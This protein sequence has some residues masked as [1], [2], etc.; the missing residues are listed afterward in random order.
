MAK[1][2]VVAKPFPYSEDGVSIRQLKEGE[3]LSFPDK[4]FDG[5]KDEGFVSASNKQ[6]ENAGLAGARD[7]IHDEMNS[8][9]VAAFDQHLAGL[10][11][12]EL[13]DVIARSGAPVSGNLVHA[14]LITAAKLQLVREAE[15]IKPVRGV[16]PNSGVTEQPLAAPG[17]P[18]PPSAAAAVERQN[19]QAAASEADV[20]IP[21]DW[22]DRHHTQQ[23]NLAK[24]IDPSVNTKAEAIDVLEKATKKA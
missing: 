16:D 11:D 19:A 10:S 24:R 23:I 8:R 7:G 18:T 4:I 1:T 20:D 9:I 14:E 22:R 2:G 5:L 3:V 13:K 21:S 17:A 12:Q 15:G 6:A